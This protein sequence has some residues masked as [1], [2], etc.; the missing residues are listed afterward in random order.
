MVQLDDVTGPNYLDGL[1]TWSLADVRAR[2][3]EATEVETGLS[4][5]RRMVQGRLDIVLAE[6]HRRQTGEGSGDVADLVDRLPA[7]LGDHVH[8]PGI[9]RL[10]ALMGPGQVDAGLAARLEEVL[11]AARLGSLPDMNDVH[12][13]TAASGL[14]QIE[15]SVSSQRRAVFDVLDRMQ[16][17]IVR[18]YRSG[19]ATVDSLLP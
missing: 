6:Q 19:E 17:E 10:P 8:A 14:D 2:R 11:P 3:D 15:R 4:Y 12:L 5:L 13:A 18:R 1:E 9:G 7:I 16:E